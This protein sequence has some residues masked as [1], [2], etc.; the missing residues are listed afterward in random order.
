MGPLQNER[1]LTVYLKNEVYGA[2]MARLQ[3]EHVLTDGLKVEIC[4]VCRLQ[5]GHV[6][7]ADW[8]T[9]TVDIVAPYVSYAFYLGDV[10]L[11]NLPYEKDLSGKI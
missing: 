2:H 5:N 11:K 6:L 9:V 8:L 4:G 10:V 3:N 1:V 7:S